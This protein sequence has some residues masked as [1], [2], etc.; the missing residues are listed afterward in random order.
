MLRTASQFTGEGMSKPISSKTSLQARARQ[1]VV[2]WFRARPWIYVPLRCSMAKDAD[3]ASRA[4][5]V[6]TDIV[7]DAF[8]R[9]GNS[10]ATVAFQTAQTKSVAVAH[11]FHA[12][13]TILFAA[14]R[15]IPAL[16]FIRNP[17][18]ACLS[19][20][21][22]RR[23]AD[24]KS[25]FQD[26]LSFYEL[27]LPVRKKLVVAR[28]ETVIRDFGVVTVRVNDVYGTR[29]TP[30]VHTPENA[31]RVEAI[32]ADRTSRQFGSDALAHGHGETPNAAKN[33]L[34]AEIATRL[35]DDSIQDLRV[36]AQAIYRIFADS[37]DV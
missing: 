26:Y 5:N 31:A 37:A 6:N 4:L 17:D 2:A 20:A 25:V 11:H 3:G 1:R 10:F 12:A 30:F 14:K 23:T 8:P 24:L 35:H 32:L 9:S 29:F 13:A 7:I 33:T 36:K 19:F 22:F 27:I 18:D 15:S 34:K 28:F 21:L 16:T